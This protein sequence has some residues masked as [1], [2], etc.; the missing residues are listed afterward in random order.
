MMIGGRKTN[1]VSVPLEDS[2]R[3]LAP[4]ESIHDSG[5][6]AARN[7]VGCLEMTAP[8]NA[9]LLAAADALVAVE[10]VFAGFG[11]FVRL[12]RA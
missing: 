1:L 10:E 8:R 11:E 12:P 6:I 4:V 5:D 2:I 3:F 7:G 9:R